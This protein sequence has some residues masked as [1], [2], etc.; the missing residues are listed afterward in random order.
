[1]SASRATRLSSS[2]RLRS[3]CSS[4]AAPVLSSCSRKASASACTAGRSQ[5]E[6]RQCLSSV[7]RRSTWL[8][9]LPAWWHMATVW[10]LDMPTRRIPHPA[11]PQPDT[12]MPSAQPKTWILA[13]AG[14]QVP[15]PGSPVPPPAP[16]APF[17]AAAA[18]TLPQPAAM[19]GKQMP[20]ILCHIYHVPSM[21]RHPPGLDTPA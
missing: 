21:P 8:A 14:G 13:E 18:Q 7:H 12:A 5:R 2:R 19:H 15:P 16:P 6:G 20:Y 4:Y 3:R 10:I 11:N 9:G 1:M 17:P